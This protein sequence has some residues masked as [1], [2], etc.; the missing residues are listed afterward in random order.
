MFKIA[1]PL[2]YNINQSACCNPDWSLN[3]QSDF[4]W[5]FYKHYL[6][7]KTMPMLTCGLWAEITVYV[8]TVPVVWSSYAELYCPEWFISLLLELAIAI[9]SDILPANDDIIAFS[10]ASAVIENN[11]NIWMNIHVHS[12][13][14]IHVYIHNYVFIHIY[15][16]FTYK[17]VHL[18][19]A[20]IYSHK[21]CSSKLRL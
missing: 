8:Y 3:S 9:T 17:Y 18:K 6:H 2:F 15:Y 12:L 16:T 19:T 13:S 4:E 7:T 1:F 20:H 5:V 10:C 21:I 11:K 14:Y